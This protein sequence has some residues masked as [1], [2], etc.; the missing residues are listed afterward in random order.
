MVS[1]N[2]MRIVAIALVFAALT[3]GILV[4][5]P[6][7]NND[8]QNGL[9]MTHVSTLTSALVHGLLFA[10]LSPVVLRCVGLIR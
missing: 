8:Y 2:V 3:P 4:N 1:R 10:L 6:P 9:F 7:V 5:L